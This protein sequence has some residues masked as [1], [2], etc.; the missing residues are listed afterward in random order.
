[1][2]SLSSIMLISSLKC[3]RSG[4]ARISHLTPYIKPY[5]K[6]IARSGYRSIA[7]EAKPNGLLNGRKIPGWIVV[8]RENLSVNKPVCRKKTQL[9]LYEGGFV[10]FPIQFF[11]WI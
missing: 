4:F 5:I 6:P 1:M 11:I 10:C 2:P 7:H 8:I 3:E 9:N